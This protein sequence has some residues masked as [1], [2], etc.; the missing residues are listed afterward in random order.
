MAV[1]LEAKTGSFGS[2]PVRCEDR[3]WVV[4]SGD[5]PTATRSPRNIFGS[6]NVVLRSRVM[7]TSGLG[8]FLVFFPYI[9]FND[10]TGFVCFTF[11]SLTFKT[12]I[13]K[14]GSGGNDRL[15]NV[16]C[17]ARKTLCSA[18]HRQVKSPN[19]F[20][21]LEQCLVIRELFFPPHT[22]PV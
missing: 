9:L 5:S 7:L 20:E 8:Q 22:K 11:C 16:C 10:S 4:V 6:C 21:L 13:S 2:S 18:S 1:E 17:S 15:G 14:K 19:L 3:E 12:D